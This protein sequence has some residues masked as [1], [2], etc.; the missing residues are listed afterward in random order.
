MR[1][2]HDPKID[3]FRGGKEEKGTMDLDI[4]I[5]NCRLLTETPLCAARTNPSAQSAS[6][7]FPNKPPFLN[8]LAQPLRLCPISCPN[9]ADV[10]RNKMARGV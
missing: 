3:S 5:L 10:I 2:C 1:G 9:D 8:P 4:M 6:L 7:A